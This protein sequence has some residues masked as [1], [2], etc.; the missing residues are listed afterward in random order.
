M[1][2]TRK[3]ELEIRGAF[4]YIIAYLSVFIC[5]ILFGYLTS[6]G[7]IFLIDIIIMSLINISLAIII[8]LRKRK[9]LKVTILS[10]ILGF[11]TTSIPIAAKYQYATMDGFTFAVRSVDTTAVLIVFVILLAFFYRPKLFVFFSAWAIFGWISFIYIAYLGGAEIHFNSHINGMG[12][13]TGL[14]LWHEI[15]FI[16]L[17]SIAFAAIYKIISEIVNKYDDKSTK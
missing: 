9:G 16:V 15:A 14:I 8:Y 4:Y 12:I 7:L 3:Q 2:Y 6:S 13:Q 5:A 17:I 10:W 11:T 1:E